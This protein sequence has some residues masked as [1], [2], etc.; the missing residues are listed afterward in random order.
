MLNPEK[1]LVYS[2]R[3]FDHTAD[4]SDRP[5]RIG[6]EI[7]ITSDAGDERHE[8]LAKRPTLNQFLKGEV[9]SHAGAAL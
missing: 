1:I 9:K 8:A 6:L 7:V 4:Q 5:A 2:T 3:W